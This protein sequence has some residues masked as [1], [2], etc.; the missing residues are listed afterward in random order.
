[1]NV[2]AGRT[3][4]L[5]LLNQDPLQ[6]TSFTKVTVASEAILSLGRTLILSGLS[7]RE[8]RT[9]VSG[10]PYLRHV[11]ILRYL[12]ST[13]VTTV[14]DAAVIILVT[15]RDAAFSDEQNR[16]ALAEFTE[17]RR[18]FIK[19]KQGTQEDMQR[20]RKRYPDWDK[21]SPNRFGSHFFML[22]NSP[23][24][25]SF[26]GQELISEDIDLGLLGPNPKQGQW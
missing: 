14:S 5:S 17:M 9:A 23:I 20:F 22:E 19:A 16:K 8:A 6:P 13:T 7:Q 1:V 26:S 3:S 25:R 21:V 4:I 15:P 12:F 24:Y 2:E 10:V 11:P 18:A